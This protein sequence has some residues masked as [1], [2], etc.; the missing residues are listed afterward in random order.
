MYARARQEHRNGPHG[1]PDVKVIVPTFVSMCVLLY[2]FV[3]WQSRFSMVV[4]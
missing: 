4:Q 2:M 3:F 1:V